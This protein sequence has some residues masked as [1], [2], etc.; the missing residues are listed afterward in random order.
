MRNTVGLDIF[1]P[2]THSPG[3]RW[4]RKGRVKSYGEEGDRVTT[5]TWLPLCLF[6]CWLKE[7]DFWPH[8][9]GW[10]REEAIR[11]CSFFPLPGKSLEEV[12]L[13]AW[14]PPPPQTPSLLLSDQRGRAR[15]IGAGILVLICAGLREKEM[16][17]VSMFCYWIDTLLRSLHIFATAL[18]SG[19]VTLSLVKR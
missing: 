1:L 7:A 5:S 13:Q 11:Q 18:W 8:L 15:G 12:H 9:S 4:E 14:V 6:S 2:C 10:G 16:N 17:Q 3:A 19:I